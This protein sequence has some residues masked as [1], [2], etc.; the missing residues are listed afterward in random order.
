MV[1]EYNRMFIQ[2]MHT[3]YL[4]IYL[5]PYSGDSI[6]SYRYPRHVLQTAVLTMLYANP[7]RRLDEPF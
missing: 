5:H 1:G 7:A 4:I 2:S 3:L 6:L